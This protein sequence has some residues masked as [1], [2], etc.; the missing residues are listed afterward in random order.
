[1]VVVASGAE[2]VKD[3]VGQA[4]D[5][6]CRRFG[7]LESDRRQLIEWLLEQQVQEV[8]ME[9]TA[10]YWRP[11][12]LDMEGR[13]GKLHLAQAQSNRAPKGRKTDFKDAKRLARRLLAGE[14]MLSFVPEAEQRSWRDAARAKDHY[15]AERA[16]LQ[17][18]VEALLEEMRIKLSGVI[19]DLFGVSGRNILAALAEG[20]KTDP[21]ELAELGDQ[22]LA[23]GKE[24]LADA[25]RGAPRPIHRKIL[26]IHLQLL[27]EYDEAIRKLDQLVAEQLK[28]HQQAVARLAE[29][30]GFGV[31]SA[32]RFIAEV[33]VD[34]EA[35]P[36]A[37]EFGSW[38]GGCPGSNITAEHNH[39]SKSPKGNAYVRKLLTQAAQAAVRTKGCRFQFLFRKFV[40][41]QTYSGAIWTIAH[42]LGKV[43]WKILHDGVRYIEYGE[44]S[45]PSAV[46]RRIQ[47]HTQAL[48][49]LGYTVTLAP[50]EPPPEAPCPA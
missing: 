39:S 43:A 12:W 27:N 24:K 33:G 21:K 20:I 14:L 15:V 17:N 38:F 36:S 30:P 37:E 10:L 8:V 32:Q 23:C 47:K 26:K 3:P 6:E 5:F 2:E 46:K 11:I 41:K 40:P 22:R 49:K 29:V 44:A 18:R 7:T 28:E 9:S 1:M 35:F 48:R 42:R 19:S 31:D 4:L 34:A 25:L 13:F 50:L 45:T 16:R